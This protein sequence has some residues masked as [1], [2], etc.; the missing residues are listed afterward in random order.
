MER[1]HRH[2]IETTI[3]LLSKA[4][5]PSTFWPYAVQTAIFL[6]N[7]LPTSI[8]HFHSPWSLLFHSKPD[9]SQLKVFGCA[10]YP[11]LRPYN[12][13]K[14]DPRTE[15]CIFL[16]YSTT[17]K[18]YLCFDPSSKIVYTSRHVLFNETKF[19]YPNLISSSQSQSPPL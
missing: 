13:H 2:L 16:G 11:L 14:L 1:K 10:C 17:S 12:S 4:S 9:I 15:E 19:S 18:G 5:I 8:L 3:T 6:V 7:L